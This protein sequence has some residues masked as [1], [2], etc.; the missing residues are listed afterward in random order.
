MLDVVY[1]IVGILAGGT[2]GWLYARQKA[3][4]EIAE[5]RAAM[6][7]AEALAEA[8][9]SEDEK[10]RAML[11]SEQK[12]VNELLKSEMENIATNSVS[13]IVE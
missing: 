4:S 6:S 10:A 12:R 5:A 9:D 1:L 7:R 3:Y 8:R 13:T 11:E 2:I